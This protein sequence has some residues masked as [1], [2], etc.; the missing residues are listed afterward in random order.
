[1]TDDFLDEVAKASGVDAD[2]AAAFA[3][4]ASAQ[5]ALDQ[6]DGDAQALK[7]DSTPSFTVTRDGGQEKVVAVGLDDLTNKLDKAL[8]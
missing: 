8:S 4:G 3:D 5:A 7:V 1:M 6:A 2:K